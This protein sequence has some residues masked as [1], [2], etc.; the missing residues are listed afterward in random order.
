[1]LR[2]IINNTQRHL[3]QSRLNLWSMDILTKK[4]LHA[5]L[6]GGGGGGKQPNQQQKTPSHCAGLHLCEAILKSV[7]PL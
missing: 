2:N 1:M 6:S 4:N 5:L 3:A 7:N